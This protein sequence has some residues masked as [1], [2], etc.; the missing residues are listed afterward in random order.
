[1]SEPSAPS[2][3]LDLNALRRAS[4]SSPA[5][6]AV[7]RAVLT[8]FATTG[9]GP[10]PASYDEV[11][12]SE[13]HQRDLVRLGL[14]GAIVVAYPF[15][16]VPTTHVVEIVDGPTVWSMCAIDALGVG[17]M[18]G[19]DTM[20]RSPDPL[21]GEPITVEIR[22]SHQT[23]NPRKAVVFVGAIGAVDDRCRTTPSVDRCCAV[24]NFFA[25]EP[26]ARAWHAAHPEVS[27]GVAD[28]ATAYRLGVETFGELLQG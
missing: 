28:Q 14:D 21:T 26:N 11:A 8:S 4:E 6:R 12:L 17:K 5:A 16:A 3:K 24:L 22:D 19:R 10:D 2:A 9:D 1:M 25:N 7:H 27:G 13:L 23:W 18:L 15:S 20:I